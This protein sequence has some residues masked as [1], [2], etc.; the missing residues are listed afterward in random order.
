MLGG[1]HTAKCLQ[2]SV[3]KYIRDFVLEESL[4]QTRIFG[5]KIVDSVLDGT[6]YVRSLKGLLILANA[7]EKLKCS[8]FTQTIQSDSITEFESNVRGLQAAYLTKDA[9]PSTHALKGI[10]RQVSCDIRDG[11]IP[12]KITKVGKHV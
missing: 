5:V 2:H 1:F 9:K 10:Y 7:I 3:G 8:A 4:H 12:G 6:H 11:T